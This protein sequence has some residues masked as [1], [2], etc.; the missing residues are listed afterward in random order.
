VLAVHRRDFRE[1]ERE[2]PELVRRLVMVMTSRIREYT[3][4]QEQRD[5][6]LSLGKLS[7]GLAHEFNN[8]VAAIARTTAELKKRV[9]RLP[10]Q[11][12]ELIKRQITPR[13]IE[14]ITATLQEKAAQG[15]KSF[16]SLEQSDLEEALTDWMDDRQVENSYI[17]AESFVRGGFGVEDLEALAAQVPP[18]A[19][20]ALLGW[21]E[22]T[23][24]TARLVAE[25]EAASRRIS[26]LVESVKIYTHMDQAADKQ[27]VNPHQGIQSTLTVMGHKL[28]E[29]H[30]RVE[31]EFMADPPLLLAY[32]SELNQVWTNLIDNAVDAMPDGGTLRI[33]TEQAG[34]FFMVRIIDNGTG[35]PADILPKIYDPFFTTKPVGKG[36]GLG[37]DVVNRLLQNHQA[38][39]TVK[40]EPGR[41]E[42]TVC[43]PLGE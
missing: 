18:S 33:K 29:K 39:I 8:P 30:V 1:M 31:T 11:M 10:E 15:T 27:P 3:K 28:S 37:L 32:V 43:F 42:F 13:Q 20:P 34:N 17:L 26:D 6:L 7:A 24:V 5:K 21:I 9:D 36:T 41:T 35:I 25:I 4:A 22:S 16:S 40:S 19:L 14:A 12:H 23:L 2:C 38:V